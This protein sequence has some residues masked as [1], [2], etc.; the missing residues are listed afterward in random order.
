MAIEELALS[1]RAYNA[2]KRHNITTVGQL[3]GLT[4]N[5]LMNIRNFGEK[6][7]TELKD[8]LVELGFAEATAGGDGSSGASGGEP[9]I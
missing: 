6:S 9:V 3:L 1:V 4:D 7:M 2:L 8:K 5:D